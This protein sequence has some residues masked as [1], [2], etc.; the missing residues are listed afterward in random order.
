[1]VDGGPPHALARARCASDY[2]LSLHGVGLSLGS[3]EPLDPDHLARLG[4]L[5]DR[6]SSRR[7]SPSTSPGA[8][9]RALP[10][11]SA[12]AALHRGGAGALVAHIVERAGRRSAGASWSRT[13]PAISPSRQRRSPSASSWPR[14]RGAPV[15]ASCSTSTTSTSA[16]ATTAST[17]RTTSRPFPPMLRR[18][19][20]SWP[21]T[22]GARSR[23]AD[24]HRRSR[25]PGRRAG[26]GAVRRDPRAPWPAADADRVGQRNP[27]RWRCS[28]TSA[29]RRSGGS[30]VPW[31][32]TARAHAA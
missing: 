23:A 1:M 32:K 18:R 10:Q 9:R 26:L 16:P 12:A 8:S 11:R 4:A 30:T 21:A 3:A 2:P 29:P 28:S 6:V 13:R 5:V 15:A 17:P 7:W 20:P 22:R 24:S 25:E 31:G 14:S 19:D 27:P